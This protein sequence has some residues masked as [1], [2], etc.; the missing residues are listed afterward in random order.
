M[1]HDLDEATSRPEVV[2]PKMREM[3]KA[4]AKATMRASAWGEGI[5][6]QEVSPWTLVYGNRSQV[7]LPTIVN[8]MTLPTEGSRPTS[9]QKMQ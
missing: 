8:G 7:G 6:F 2:V 5:P 4:R 9:G 1:V 3:A